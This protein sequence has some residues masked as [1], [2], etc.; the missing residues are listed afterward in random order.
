M[1]SKDRADELQGHHSISM[2]SIPEKNIFAVNSNESGLEPDSFFDERI[3]A[4]DE[5][6]NLP[7]GCVAFGTAKAAS[8]PRESWE[9]WT[10]SGDD[11]DDAEE[12]F[13]VG[14]DRISEES[15]QP[16]KSKVISND[17]ATV[18]FFVVSAH[19][20]EMPLS[21]ILY[22]GR[23]FLR[24]E[25]SKLEQVDEDKRVQLL[26]TTALKAEA[27]E[28][29]EQYRDPDLGF[30]EHKE[31]I[32]SDQNV[33]AHFPNTLIGQVNQYLVEIGSQTIEGRAGAYIS[34][35]ASEDSGP[36]TTVRNNQYS[37]AS[38]QRQ[39]FY[40]VL[41]IIRG[42]D[43]VWINNNNLNIE[44][45]ISWSLEQIQ[46]RG[47]LQAIVDSS[48]VLAGLGVSGTISNGGFSPTPYYDSGNTDLF[49]NERAAAA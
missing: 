34:E 2:E 32:S 12:Q 7:T 38:R 49:G 3:F 19:I 24:K 11:I 15:G 6:D 39:G 1:F 27:D 40:E 4:R 31:T 41:K 10:M 5:S 17:D 45:V 48:I 20:G 21:G 43:G 29:Y 9:F 33:T 36:T 23:E 16:I 28:E 46:Q 30:L 35:P 25:G 22:A 18:S 44:Y 14:I 42:D 8:E 37:I 13:A 26:A 47:D